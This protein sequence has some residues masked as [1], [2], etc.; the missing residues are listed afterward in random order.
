MNFRKVIM[1]PEERNKLSDENI[2]KGIAELVYPKNGWDIYRNNSKIDPDT[3]I[4]YEDSSNYEQVDYCNNW[5][6]LMALVVEHK[7]FFDNFPIDIMFNKRELAECL[8][9]ALQK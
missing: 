9:L 1:T 6:D 8:L 4:R 2:T 5:N 3:Y 7:E